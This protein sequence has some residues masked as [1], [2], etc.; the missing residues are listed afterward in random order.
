MRTA[1]RRVW[2]AAFTAIASLFAPHA[3]CQEHRLVYELPVDA[4]Q[5]SLRGVHDTDLEHCLAQC[6][7]VIAARVGEDIQ[8]ERHEATGFVV[9]VPQARLDEL[10]RLRRRIEA[11]GTLE[12]RMVASADARGGEAWL[13]LPAERARLQA[14]LDTGGRERVLADTRALDAFHA[15]TDNGPIARGKLRWCVHR[16]TPRP[17]APGLWSTS[18]AQIPPLQAACV[19]VYDATQWNDGTVPAADAPDATPFL[20]ELIALDL[21]QGGFTHQDL[22]LKAVRVNRGRIPAVV[23]RVRPDRIPAY[24]EWSRNNIGRCSAVIWNGEIVM[25]PRFE[26]AIPGVGTILGDF[27]VDE[28][29]DIANALRAG[30]LPVAPRLVQQDTASTK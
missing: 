19:P 16:I 28:L 9:T 3:P 27:T 5:R 21:E 15:D 2:F 6:V 24:H 1:Y 7:S 26:S 13:D 17:E 29:E 4:L 23:Y 18:Y 25:A 20:F 8:V 10:P 12:M 22:D 30:A 14:W 11:A